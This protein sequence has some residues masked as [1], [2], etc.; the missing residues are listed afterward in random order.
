MRERFSSSD[1]RTV[2]FAFRPLALIDVSGLVLVR[3]RAV[4]LAILETPLV[5]LA[6]RV[7]I[8]PVSVRPLVL[9]LPVV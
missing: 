2:P 7:A 1:A 5:L 6:V 9:P 8:F 4:E 3:A